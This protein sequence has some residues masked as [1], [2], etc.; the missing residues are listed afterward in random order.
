MGSDIAWD[1]VRDSLDKVRKAT[2]SASLRES[3]IS[4]IH[5]AYITPK[6]IS[7]WAGLKEETCSKCHGSSPYIINYFWDCPKILKSS[8]EGLNT[9]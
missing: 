5:K 2:L 3:Q 6:D 4:I 1:E 9:G 8:G 7:R